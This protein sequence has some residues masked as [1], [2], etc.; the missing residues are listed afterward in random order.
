[1]RNPSS[2]SGYVYLKGNDRRKK[3]A[4]EAAYSD[5]GRKVKDAL[6]Q[7][8]DGLQ[9]LISDVKTAAD[10]GYLQLLDKRHIPVRSQHAAL[11]TLLQAA[12]AII[13]KRWVDHCYDKV[14]RLGIDARLHAFIH[15][16]AEQSVRRD[17][18]E[19]FIEES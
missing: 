1:E 6:E 8:I 11:N 13:A 7:G 17:Q 2:I 14:K 5:V 4:D 19:Q 16:E 3:T 18:V 10:R 9:D 15:D 12:A